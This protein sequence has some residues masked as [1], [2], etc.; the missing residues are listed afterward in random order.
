MYRTGHYGVS[1]LLY[2]PV[3]FA[4]LVAG[5]P[6]VCLLGGAAML[7]LAPL[8]DYDLRVPFVEHRGP[9]HTLAFALLV[10]GVL[11]GASYAS[12][13]TLGLD[14]RVAG[15]AGVV[16]GTYGI[17]AHLVG[18]VLTP[19]G[20]APFWPV[21]SRNYSLSVTRADSTVANTA[22]LALGVVLTVVAA[23][24]GGRVG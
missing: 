7:A 16:V 4:L 20:I 24:V 2:A 18:D 10:G 6:A 12:A 13:P 5:Y 1:L 11:G 14:P 22:L 8:P 21:S 3:G 17:V 9:T 23:I 19:A 15:L